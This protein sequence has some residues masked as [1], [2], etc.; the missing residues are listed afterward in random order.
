M[1]Y[2]EE[3][4]KEAVDLY[5]SSDFGLRHTANSIGVSPETLRSWISKYEDQQESLDITERER[6][7]KA[8]REIKRLEEENEILK[9]AAA[10]FAQETTKRR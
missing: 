3:F 4:K 1:R 5:R 9:K 6:L 2:T 10:F 8:E 7:R